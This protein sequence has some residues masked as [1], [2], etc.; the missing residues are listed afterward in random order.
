MSIAIN[1][2]HVELADMATSFLSGRG[3]LAEARAGLDQEHDALPSFFNEMVELGWLGLHLPEEVGGA[4]FGIPELVVVLEQMGAHLTPG[5]LL[6][7]VT[8]SSIIDR[9]GSAELKAQWLE[10]LAS[11]ATVGTVA[12]AAPSI[13][14]G[15]TLDGEVLCP[16]GAHRAGLCLLILGD[17]VV[18][19]DLSASSVSV[20]ERPS[21]DPSRHGSALQFSGHQIAEGQ[22]LAGAGPDATALARILGAAEAA[23]VARRTLDEAVAYAKVREQFGRVIGTFQAVKHHCA[24]MLVASE[25][26]TA[27][28]D[29][30]ARVLTSG[31]TSEQIQL[32]GAVAA[33]QT[34]EAAVLNAELNVQVHGGIGFTW[35]HDAQLFVRRAVAL[36]GYLSADWAARDVAALRLAGVARPQGLELPPEAES[37]R[38][39][40]RAAAQELAGLSGTEQRA[41]FI[42]TGYVMPHWPKPYGRA[43]S[44]LE[45]L[46]I[47]QEFEAAALKRPEYGITGWVILTIIEHGSEEQVERW[48]RRTLEGDW[49]WCQLFSEPDAG[50]DAAAVRTRG[51]KVE[52]GWIVT[53]QK[54]WTSGAHYSRWGFATVR[55]DPNMGKHGGVT[56]MVIDMEAPEVEVRPLRQATGGADFNEVFLQGVFVPDDDVVG[57]VDNGWS[58]ARATLGNERVSIGGGAGGG[59]GIDVLDL[60]RRKGWSDPSLE[61]ELGYLLAERQ[62]MGAINLRSIMRAVLGA[63]PGPE[64]NVTKLLTAEG[65]QRGARF[66][67]K[68][69]GVEAAFDEGDGAAASYGVFSG[70]AMSI[71]GG[72]SEITRNQI[73]ER[74][75]GLPRDPLLSK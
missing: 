51:E 55:T 35:E 3:S 30:A 19:V 27:A 62:S 29:D 37:Y 40:T 65:T 39:E 2:T 11:G 43:A 4:G 49:V 59:M 33:A 75:L 12:F 44:A 69:V 61:L 7:A 58:V 38:A 67:R 26:A 71:A 73:A 17:D 68:V 46:V 54:V 18:V 60:F 74:I 52:G 28:V 21:F 24:N 53:G 1:E 22:V 56:M 13:R 23:G 8:A 5:P 32:V 14:Q 20:E 41:R 63:G 34:M 10:S 16:L 50:S 45:Q 48:V 66:A 31:G 64:G 42:D 72:T 70:R 25:L 15:S 6:G 36:A 47:E 9:L 57:P